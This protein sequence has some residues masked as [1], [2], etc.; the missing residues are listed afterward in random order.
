MRNKQ[1]NEYLGVGWCHN[2]DRTG[3]TQTKNNYHFLLKKIVKNKK[4][5]SIKKSLS[6]YIK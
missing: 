6:M 4:Y 3:F 1:K 5:I 2:I